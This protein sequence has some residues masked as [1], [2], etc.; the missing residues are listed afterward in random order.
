VYLLQPFDLLL[1]ICSA[2]FILRCGLMDEKGCSWTLIA[3]QLH[4]I[5]L[6]IRDEG[7]E[8]AVD[9]RE[10]GATRVA[11]RRDEWGVGI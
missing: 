6:A 11:R 10:G 5:N 4:L 9:Q 3:A 2:K 8:Q 1:C 7:Q